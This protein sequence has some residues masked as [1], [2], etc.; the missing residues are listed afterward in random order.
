M[1]C[2]PLFII[3]LLLASPAVPEPLETSLQRNL[4]GAAL[5]DAGMKSDNIFLRGICCS[6]HPPCCSQF[7]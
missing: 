4:I 2:L 7:Q 1:L 3:L 5:R 6:K